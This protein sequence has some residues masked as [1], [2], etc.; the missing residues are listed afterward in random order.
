MK[1]KLKIYLIL[2]AILS[3]LFAVPGYAMDEFVDPFGTD[4]R[5]NPVDVRVTLNAPENFDE[6]VEIF[7]DKV[8]YAMYSGSGYQLNL[9]LENG[10]HSMVVLSST[11]VV[12]QYEFIYDDTWNTN[13]TQE[14]IIDV[15]FTDF[16]DTQF[17][18]SWDDSGFTDVEGDEMLIETP[19]YYDFSEGYPS[20]I[21]HVS[22]AS[23]PAFEDVTFTLVGG[24]ENKMYEI[25]LTRENWF[26]ADVILPAGSY[27][28]SSNF[29]FTYSEGVSNDDIT[30]LWRHA[31]NLGTYGD[32]YDITEGGEVTLSDLVIYM[33]YGSEIAEVNT[34]VLVEK[35]VRE[36]QEQIKEEHFQK[37]LQ[38]AFPEDYTTEA[39]T[40]AEAQPVEPAAD[41]SN[42]IQVA[43]I[44]V[45][46]L[47]VIGIAALIIRRRKS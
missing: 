39:E 41:Y 27:Y 5:V 7:I 25:K 13:S 42:I 9:T 3:S 43:V 6:R 35:E 45:L 14:I 18:A 34:N 16:A 8:E 36:K 21:F 44:A 29:D 15:Q 22:C 1:N 33:N 19:A 10:T 12:D 26:K 31:D 40:I 37:E 4:E 28:E 38:E 24:P 46:V 32:Y 2:I 23:Y 11:D 30:F 17:N 20:G 47:T